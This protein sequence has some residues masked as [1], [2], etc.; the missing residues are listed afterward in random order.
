MTDIIVPPVPPSATVRKSAVR[1]SIS[2]TV[3]LGGFGWFLYRLGEMFA[4]HS[5]WGYFRTPVGVGEMLQAGGAF[6]M[7]CVGALGVNVRDL[8]ARKVPPT[9]KE[10]L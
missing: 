1:Q 6:L 7:T 10:S 2:V 8:F 9:D 5:E 4:L 3:F